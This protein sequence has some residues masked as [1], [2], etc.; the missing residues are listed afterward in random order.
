MPAAVAVHLCSIKIP[1]RSVGKEFIAEI[2]EIEREI[3]NGV[4]DGARELSLYLSRQRTLQTEKRRLDVFEKF[5][6]KIATFSAEIVGRKEIPDIKP[7]LRRIMKYGEE[8]A[9]SIDES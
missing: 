2:P 3:L 6:P 9:S 8:E 5:L 4:R 1:Y 7:L